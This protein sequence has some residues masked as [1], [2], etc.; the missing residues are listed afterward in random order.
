MLRQWEL[1]V[2][3]ARAVGAQPVGAYMPAIKRVLIS[4][5]AGECMI[6]LLSVHIACHSSITAEAWWQMVDRDHACL[7]R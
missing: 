7:L 2:L 4:D 6:V 3:Y 5:I 1:L